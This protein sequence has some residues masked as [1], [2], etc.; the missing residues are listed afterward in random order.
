MPIPL[1]EVQ[2]FSNNAI[3]LL[4]APISETSTSLTVMAG[5]GALFPNPGPNEFFLITLEDQGATVREIIKVTGRVDDTLFFNLA[6]RGQEGTPILA[7]PS[8][9]GNETLVDH[10]VTAETMQRAM[11]LP[12]QPTVPPQTPALIVQDEGSTVGTEASTLNFVGPA[13]QVTGAGAVKT[14]TVTGGAAWINGENTST[15]ID[16]GWQLPVSS[17]VYSDVNR[18]FKY[19]VTVQHLSSHHV[20]AFEIMLTI[21]GNI[22][23]DE[24]VTHAT[25]YATVGPVINGEIHAILDTNT[26]EVRL[27]WQNAEITP[28]RVQATR[29]QHGPVI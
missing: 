3:S 23:A 27:E 9:P 28:V 1:T 14:V 8:A 29:V 13:V 2:L 11:L 12:E 26:K 6:D 7:W 18:T 5:Y 22:A 10:R 21:S 24:E 19:V 4:T 16:P 17:A 25:Q 20:R 15:L